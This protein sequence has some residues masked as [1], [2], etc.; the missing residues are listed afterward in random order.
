L[1]EKDLLKFLDIAGVIIV[2]LD[3]DGKV[4][5]INKKG[6]EV[7]G[8]SEE[9]IL[10]KNWFNNFIPEKVR[11]ETL[12]VFG[13]LMKGEV[14]SAEYFENPVLTANGEERIILWHNTILKDELGRIKGTLSSGN[15]ITEKKRAEEK[16][17][18]GEKKLKAIVESAKDGIIMLNENGEV[19]FWNKAAEEIFGYKSEEIIGKNLHRIIAPEKYRD[20]F[21]KGFKKFKKTGKGRVVGKTLELSILRKDGK[22]IYIELSVSG[23]KLNGRWNAVGIVRDITERKRA[24]RKLRESEERL[25]TIMNAV[26]AG[27]VVIDAEKH[28]IVDINP[29]AIR[30]IGVS[31]E[32]IIGKKCHEH[33]CPA[34]VGKCP[35]TDLNQTVDMS[36]RLL[37]TADGKKVPVLKT[38]KVIKLNNRKHI[39]ES[40]IDISERKKLERTQ[41]QLNEA[42]K[43]INKILRHDILNDL[44]VIKG[45]IEVY[46]ESKDDELL[47]TAL[48]SIDKSVDLIRKMR[49]VESVTSTGGSLK[50]MSAREVIDEV[51][52]NYNIEINIEG[53]CTVMVDDAFSSV[54]D[55]LIRNAIVHG[56]TE[57]IDISIR[58][59]GN[60]CEIRVSDY[61]RGISDEIKDRIFEE[62]F[63]EGKTMGTGLGLYITSKILERYG[64]K[65]WVEDNK[66]KGTVFVLRLKTPSK[67]LK[68]TCSSRT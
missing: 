46:R 48:K 66:P 67:V 33:I 26:Q 44:T 21:E 65:I 20:K 49:E 42:L 68:S 8:Y 47:T 22:E 5:Y 6:C 1:D 28:E 38:A 59:S 56:E 39:V 53:D 62:G 7:L 32:N 40:F 41:L 54:I 10:G 11:K 31:R 64:G 17:R 12:D 36:E 15:D 34:E 57:K 27:I 37:I 51:I 63:T 55:N 52:K 45:S 25:K 29:A 35:I 14:Q 58:K 16:L 19:T 60:E 50:M 23:V 9:E 13:K 18:E 24:E 30:M 2:S 61:G 3:K 43:L 4:S